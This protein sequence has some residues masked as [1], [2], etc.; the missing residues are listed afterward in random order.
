ME[1]IVT[2]GAGYLGYPVV[3]KLVELDKH[4]TVLDVKDSEVEG[5]GFIQCDL[6]NKV[7]V[8]EALAELEN[9]NCKF[10]HLAALFV[11]NMAKRKETKD[12]DYSRLNTNA[13]KNLI[14]AISEKEMKIKSF[15]FSST[16]LCNFEE[17]VKN[18][19]YTRTKY[20]SEQEVKRLQH[21]V[22]N[23]QIV[24]FSRVIGLSR[25]NV[26]PEDII[27]DFMKLI[28]TQNP[29]KVFGPEIVRDYIHMDDARDIL[30]H[31]SDQNGFATKNFF[32]AQPT[33]MRDLTELI[34]QALKD[35][36]LITEK[37]IAYE[38][39]SDSAQ[40]WKSDFPAN[41]L[42]CDTSSKAI[43][44]AIKEYMPFFKK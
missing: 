19:P 21:D 15:V 1:Y 25:L 23:V 22:P 40:N 28:P 29:F 7:E 37:E 18:D 43:R 14:D 42:K 20:E 41:M 24:R 8:D 5:A 10:I 6:S 17:L 4:T 36:G 39:K 35:E 11:K 30:L 32:T 26:L 44:L 33:S 2:G 12:E 9:N 34:V 31:L 38:P 16:S 3:R 27:S 13:T